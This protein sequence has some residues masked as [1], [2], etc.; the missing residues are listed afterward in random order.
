MRLFY[1]FSTLCFLFISL[2]SQAQFKNP[3]R[4]QVYRNDVVPRIDITIAANLLDSIYDPSHSSYD[5]EY[6]ANFT[7]NN[8]VISETITEVGFRL[9]GNTSRAA[10]KKSFKISFNTF[11]AGRK[12]YGLEKLNL[13]GEHND[14]S[15]SRARV[16][17]DVLRDLDLPAP[18]SNHVRLY[19]NGS[20][21]GLYLNVEHIDEEFVQ[22]RFGNQDGNLYKCLWPADLTYKGSTGTSYKY[23][24]GS[25]RVY[26]LKTNTT[27]DNYDDL[28]QLIN[29]INN[30]GTANLQQQLDPIFDVNSY[31]AQL[32]V[33]VLV[34]HWDGY[35]YNKNNYYLYKNTNSGKFEFIH[36]DVDNTLGIDWVGR[37]W[38]TRDIYSW[39]KGGEQR[40]LFTKLMQV[41]AYRERYS[42]FINKLLS[43]VYYP[44]RMAPLVNG[45]RDQVKEYVPD[46]LYRTLDYGYDYN[47]FI[48]SF[49]HGQG[50]HVVEGI[51]LFISART[52]SAAQQLDFTSSAPVIWWADNSIP[53]QSE[54]LEIFTRV[55]DDQD[56]LTVSLE[57][58]IDDVFSETVLLDNGLLFDTLALDD[59]YRYLISDLPSSY[60]LQYRIKAEDQDGR[61]SYFPSVGYIEI[62]VQSAPSVEIAINEVMSANTTAHLDD[63]N[64]Y[65][66]WVELYNFGSQSLQLS[67]YFLSDNPLNRNK[68][69]LP[70]RVLNPGEF[71]VFWADNQ[72]SQGDI[73]MNFKISASGETLGLYHG[74]DYGQATIDEVTI[75]ALNSDQSWGRQPD[76]NGM[77]AEMGI[78]TPGGSNHYVL[79]T[80][81][82]DF[83]DI[84]VYPN[85]ASE[86]ITINIQGDNTTSVSCFSI[87][88]NLVF[89]EKLQSGEQQFPIKGLK[90]GVYI[91]NFNGVKEQVQLR[92]IVL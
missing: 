64:E 41:P 89:K 31:L 28:A 11:V 38:T 20:Y 88:G 33:E 10:E 30:A 8:G 13:N 71:I 27:E 83:T 22:S 9:R 90:S 82:D 81:G 16:I 45:I 32:A 63:M 3:P 61:I 85:P 74:P 62:N 17:W 73:H 91:L 40:P 12:F 78:G 34:G 55:E 5:I 56:M 23:S 24:N 7:F 92:L 19:I 47:D 50:G 15:I 2:I 4:G 18:R 60:H 87:T 39:S 67:D 36:Y 35:S 69:Q 54:P 80:F 84:Q 79:S 1:Y 53:L 43:E 14:P 46:D 68:W 6:P 58:G 21:Y 42:Y 70:N 51:N 86:Y 72:P 26:D 65:D 77:F 48:N 52:S 75:P 29:V 76:G 66:D 44:S 37:D 57:I 49:L 59:H 25:R